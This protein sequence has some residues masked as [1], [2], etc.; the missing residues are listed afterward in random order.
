MGF[1]RIQCNTKYVKF[2]REASGS[3]AMS[4]S[5]I[6][7]LWSHVSELDWVDIDYTLNIVRYSDEG[8]EGIDTYISMRAAGVPHAYLSQ[9]SALYIADASEQPGPSIIALWEAGVGWLYG[10]TLIS[11]FEAADI[12]R[13]HKS[14]ISIDYALD[15]SI[16]GLDA[17]RV[18]AA[19]EAGLPL[20]YATA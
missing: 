10:S 19:H 16:A 12:I 13:M 3:I 7:L 1:R 17:D 9:F 11:S 2:D 18:V 4:Q 14:G 20:E 6:D 8:R 15:C 5:D